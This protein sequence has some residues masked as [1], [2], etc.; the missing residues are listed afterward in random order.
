MKAMTALVVLS[1]FLA[2]PCAALELIVKGC[3]G[4]P[5]A[6]AA[7][8]EHEQR[9]VIVSIQESS[10]GTRVSARLTQ[11]NQ[12]PL[13]R[14]VKNREAVF[15]A[16]AGGEWM[17][18]LTPSDAKVAR[19]IIEEPSLSRV[20]GAAAVG[21]AGAAGIAVAVENSRGGGS[22]ASASAPVGGGSQG[23]PGLPGGDTP[24]VSGG[25]G[26]LPAD[27]H[28]CV[29]TQETNPCMIGVKPVPTNILSIYE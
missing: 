19:V 21:V 10:P 17:L 25:S 2:L 3:D 4:S 12:S 20:I 23:A 28:P 15:D 7:L 6:M 9:R 29:T 5:L 16:V 11:E 22:S 1:M 26:G 27:E 14:P 24:A 8:K 18:C 13:D